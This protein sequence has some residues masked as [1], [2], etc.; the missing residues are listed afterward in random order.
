MGKIMHGD[1]PY[2]GGGGASA[3]SNL[4]DVDLSN[5]SDGQILKYDAQ[6][7]KWINA[8][9]VIEGAYAIDKLFEQNDFTAASGTSEV[10]HSY[11]LSKSI[12]EYDA[13][14][15]EVWNHNQYYNNVY[16]RTHLQTFL[17]LK[18]DY[19]TTR[20]P[21]TG[22]ADRVF[23]TS[24]N[25]AGN[26]RRLYFRFS[27]STTINT[28]AV[29]SQNN[30]EPKLYRVFGI[31]FGTQ[32]PI[33]YDLNEREVGVWVDGKPLYQ[34]TWSW[35]KSDFIKANNNFYSIGVS[36]LI[37][38]LDKIVSKRGTLYTAS[39]GTSE[40]GSYNWSN[41]SRSEWIALTDY[42]NQVAVTGTNRT[43]LDGDWSVKVT[44]LYTKTTDTAGS[45]K[46]TTLGTPTVHYSENEQIIG[47]W[48]DGKPLYQKTINVG[49]LSGSASNTQLNH[50]IANIDKIVGIETIGVN[51]QSGASKTLDT[52][53]TQAGNNRLT[54]YVSKT[55]VNVYHENS[56][57][58]MRAFVTVRYTKTT[59]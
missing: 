11:T 6:N 30:E 26:D 19:Y 35:A 20:E 29:R 41:N 57:P 54:T 3:L 15:V 7:Q 56:A 36:P 50:N 16:T 43:A 21:A 17:V 18:S 1:M 49:Y 51:E 39:Y 55:L 45:G 37:S 38:N 42:Y 12:D 47:T 4:T 25:F 31:R 27:N 5:P 34:C 32:S 10:T 44:Y 52:P 58:T 59:D 9:G 22:N 40:L 24:A 53:D 8:N 2:G 13:V 48:I 28:A 23:F 33:V 46:Y 14:L